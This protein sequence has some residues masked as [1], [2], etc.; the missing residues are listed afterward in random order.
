VG[1]EYEAVL[2]SLVE[3]LEVGVGVSDFGPGS[4]DRYW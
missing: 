1:T 2:F 4:S 3:D